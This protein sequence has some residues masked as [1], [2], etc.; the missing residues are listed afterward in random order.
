MGASSRAGRP[1]RRKAQ[2]G[3]ARKPP[4]LATVDPLAAT[5][6]GELVHLLSC[7]DGDATHVLA[8]A[9]GESIRLGWFWV[10]L[11]F[12]CFSLTRQARL[13][14]VLRVNSHLARARRAMLRTFVGVKNPDWQ[15]VEHPDDLGQQALRRLKLAV[16]PQVQTPSYDLLVAPRLVQIL[17]DAVGMAPTGRAGLAELVSAVARHAMHPCIGITLGQIVAHER[18]LELLAA[19]SHALTT[20]GDPRGARARGGKATRRLE[21]EPWTGPLDGAVMVLDADTDWGRGGTGPLAFPWDEDLDDPQARFSR[22]AAGWTVESRSSR[23]RTHLVSQATVLE[24]RRV[25]EP[26]DVLAA[27]RTW[28]RVGPSAQA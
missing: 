6:D 22:D 13:A 23:R 10:G 14:S 5:E 9:C 1:R 24:T 8:S 4:P 26:G 16:P 18:G 28:L 25:L 12:L 27:S 20:F 15:S 2:P 3:A 21:V 19:D 17:R 11:E 7:L